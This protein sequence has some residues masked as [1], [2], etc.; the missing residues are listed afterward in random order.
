MSNVALICGKIGDVYNRFG[1]Y[2]RDQKDFSDRDA[3]VSACALRLRLAA[4]YA[5]P[6][7]EGVA[8]PAIDTSELAVANARRRSPAWLQTPAE[9][10]RESLLMT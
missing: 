6:R 9:D 1:R 7:G 2:S 8:V 10:R 4:Y 3:S 5:S